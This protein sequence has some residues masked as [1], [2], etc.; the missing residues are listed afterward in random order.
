VS[1]DTYDSSNVAKNGNCCLKGMEAFDKAQIVD[2]ILDGMGFVPKVA[3]F[4]HKELDIVPTEGYPDY[5]V[6]SAPTKVGFDQGKVDTD[7]P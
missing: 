4:D 6:D 7:L 3:Y 2:S 1:L 5:K